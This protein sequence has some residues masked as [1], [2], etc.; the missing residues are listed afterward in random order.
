MEAAEPFQ[1]AQAIE[2][3]RAR[4]AVLAGRHESVL[5]EYLE[6]IALLEDAG[7]DASPFLGAALQDYA[8]LLDEVGH[9]SEAAEVRLRINSLG[10]GIQG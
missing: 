5:A 2:R 3:E 1:R 7:A 6:L 4:R 10:G 9:A 8:A